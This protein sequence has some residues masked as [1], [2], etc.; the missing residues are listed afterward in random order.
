[1][2]FIIFDTEY[3]SWKGCLENGWLG[4]QKKEIVQISALKVSESLEI[5]DKFSVLCKPTVNPILSDYFMNLTKITNKNIEK[6]GIPFSLAYEKF[7]TFV[8]SD[9]C[10]SHGW[11]SDYL[12]KSDGDIISQNLELY[13][14]KD[15]ETL[16][17][18]NI[19]PVFKQLYASNNISVE[20][21]SSGQIVKILKIENKLKNLGLNPHNALYDV[22]SILEGLKY[23]YPESVKLI[24]DFETE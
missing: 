8:G 15:A 18:R 2:S 3:T 16:S 20:S 4:K 12:N 23:F 14:I 7:K 5:I 11:G 21:Q 24:N 13:N 10:Y 22:Y 19:A 6:D 17:Y 9:I 1:M